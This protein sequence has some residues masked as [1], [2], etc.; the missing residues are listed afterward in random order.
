MVLYLR[1]GIADLGGNVSVRSKGR[2]TDVYKARL[3]H[4]FEA[5]AP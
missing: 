2:E 4:Q 1:K 3:I 5:T